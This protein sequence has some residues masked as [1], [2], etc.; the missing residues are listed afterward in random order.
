LR[1]RTRWQENERRINEENELIRMELDDTKNTLQTVIQK[2]E[3]DV[4][5]TATVTEKKAEEVMSKYRQQAQVQSE[6]LTIIQV[7]Y[8]KK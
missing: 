1:D 6:N 7:F 4:K 8:K 2:A 3:N 5:L